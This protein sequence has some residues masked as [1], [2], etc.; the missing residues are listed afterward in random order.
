VPGYAGLYEVTGT[1]PAGVASGNVTITVSVAG[2]TSPPVQ[3]SVATG[4]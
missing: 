3:V 2:V 4:N 1:M